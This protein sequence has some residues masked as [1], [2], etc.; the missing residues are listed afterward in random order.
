MNIEINL[1]TIY[2]HTSDTIIETQ[3]FQDFYKKYA[4]TFFDVLCGTIE[5]ILGE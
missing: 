3:G 2:L 5:D 4:H 1:T